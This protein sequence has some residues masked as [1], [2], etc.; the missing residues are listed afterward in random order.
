MKTNTQ[1]SIKI[2]AIYL[3]V[4]L[5]KQGGHVVMNLKSGLTTTRIKVFEIPVKYFVI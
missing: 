2:D 3:T 5:N 4:N 1:A